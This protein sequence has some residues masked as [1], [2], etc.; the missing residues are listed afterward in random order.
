MSPART[1]ARADDT[2]VRFGVV[3]APVLAGGLA[4][5]TNLA[6]FEVSRPTYFLIWGAAH[7]LVFAFGLWVAGL[8]RRRPSTAVCVGLG[9]LAG[10]TEAFVVFRILD[11]LTIVRGGWPME[12]V[13]GP[14]DYAGVVATVIMFAAGA[15]RGIRTRVESGRAGGS[16]VAP[17]AE[18]TAFFSAAGPSIVALSTLLKVVL[19]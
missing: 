5:A 6:L 13:T 10:A 16:S 15:M 19:S 4:A 14:E 2:S 7:L 1:D 18:L 3:A 12:L 9:L 8:L 17:S 11:H